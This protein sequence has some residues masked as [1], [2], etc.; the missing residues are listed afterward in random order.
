MSDRRPFPGYA[1][2]VGPTHDWRNPAPDAFV[3]VTYGP[4]DADGFSDYTR[5]FVA[6]L[7]E[8]CDAAGIA[9]S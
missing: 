2:L 3:W 7:E 9:V 1:A 4:P 8:A 6:S 5:G